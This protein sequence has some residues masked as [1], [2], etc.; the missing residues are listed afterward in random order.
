[1]LVRTVKKDDAVEVWVADNGIGISKELQAR[2]F[3][4]FITTKPGGAGIGLA[5]SREIVARRYGG[6]LSVD[7]DPGAYTAFKLM[8]PVH[9]AQLEETAPAEA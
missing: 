7:S 9:K 8:L 3:E 2:V 6:R 4:P 5:L 1:V